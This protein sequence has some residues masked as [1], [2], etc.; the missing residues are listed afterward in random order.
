VTSPGAKVVLV[1]DDDVDIRATLADVLV[2]EGYTVETAGDG[3]DALELL[4][5]GLAPGLI[6]LDLMMPRCDGADF[7][8]AQLADPRLAGFPVVLLSATAKLDEKHG[9][10]RADAY[11]KKPVQLDELLATVARHCR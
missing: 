5:G 2:D 7:R 3:L 4:R 6:L 10:L 1:V 8:Q 9:A 11:L